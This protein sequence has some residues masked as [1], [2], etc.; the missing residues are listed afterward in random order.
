MLSYLIFSIITIS[1]ILRFFIKNNILWTIL[2]LILALLIAISFPLNFNFQLKTLI[3]GVILFILSVIYFLISSFVFN[4]QI[5]KG[6]SKIKEY[7][8]LFRILAGL[9]AGISEEIIYRGFLVIFLNG[10]FHNIFISSTISFFLF[11]IAHIPIW[12]ILAS[13][14][15]SIWSIML[16]VYFANTNDILALIVAHSLNDIFFFCCFKYRTSTKR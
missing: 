9:I 4:F 15:I 7:N 2:K 8:F 6:L 5:L 10:F 1:T 14:Q 11:L 3:F 13:I 16:Y 12:G